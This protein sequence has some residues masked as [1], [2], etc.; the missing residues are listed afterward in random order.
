M[1]ESTL[2]AQPDIPQAIETQAQSAEGESLLDYKADTAPKLIQLRKDKQPQQQEF[3]FAL[4]QGEAL[5]QLPEDLYIPPS[6][7]EVFLEA[8]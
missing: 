8:F 4:V 7:L 6:A 3:P 5:T 1:T 2:E